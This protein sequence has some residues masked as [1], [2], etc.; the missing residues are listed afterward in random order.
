MLLAITSILTSLGNLFLGVLVLR[1]NSKSPINRF[2]FAF[3]ILLAAYILTSYASV[4]LESPLLFRSTFVISVLLKTIGFLW[5]FSLCVGY[6]KNVALIAYIVALAI[7]SGLVLEGFMIGNIKYGDQ[8]F[9]Y[10]I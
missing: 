5:V 8:F 2:F 4:Y 3:T 10:I 6:N 1:K 7:I 9:D